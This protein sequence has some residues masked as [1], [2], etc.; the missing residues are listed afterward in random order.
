MVPTT[1]MRSDMADTITAV[2]SKRLE[3]P[4]MT[5]ELLAREAGTDPKYLNGIL[6]GKKQPGRELSQRIARALGTTVEKLW[7]LAEERGS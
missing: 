7:P 4:G 1:G 3:I 2:E 5:Q 6:R